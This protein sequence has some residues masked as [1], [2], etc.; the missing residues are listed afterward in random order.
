MGLA[1]G[2]DVYVILANWPSQRVDHWI[3]LIKARAIENQAY[4][5][6][7]NRVGSDPN[8][9]YPGRSLVADPR[10]RV[11]ADA[12]PRESLLQIDLHVAQ[13]KEWRGEF[14]A[15]DDRKFQASTDITLPC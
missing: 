15:L 6:G 14:P 13:V 3:S 11:I 8:I 2:V 1:S 5:V 4:V 10:G 12:G 7:V 9:G